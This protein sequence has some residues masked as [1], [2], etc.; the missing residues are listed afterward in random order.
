M[1]NYNAGISATW[2]EFKCSLGS[3]LTMEEL[4]SLQESPQVSLVNETDVTYT[5]P[6]PSLPSVDPAL[7]DSGTTGICKQRDWLS[8]LT[9]TR[10]STLLWHL[11]VAPS[12]M[13]LF[14]YYLSLFHVLI[15]N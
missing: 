1:N 5:C 13:N 11:V 6:G 9:W 14:K 4:R 15:Y 12:F 8:S 10:D 2:I 3:E 7:R